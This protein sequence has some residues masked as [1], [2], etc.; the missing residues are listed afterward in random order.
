V[1]PLVSQDLARISLSRDIQ[2]PC[3]ER[4]QSV[5]VSSEDYASGER[6]VE[7][8]RPALEKMDCQE[9]QLRESLSLRKQ[10]RVYRKLSLGAK[11][12][13]RTSSP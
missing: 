7:T 1:A 3:F 2:T 13:D 5:P 9:V 4:R 12:E 11:L 8:A 6:K 10:S